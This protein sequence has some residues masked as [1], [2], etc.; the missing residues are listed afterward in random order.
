MVLT[1]FTIWEFASEMFERAVAA[2]LRSLRA[3]AAGGKEHPGSVERKT[4][5]KSNNILFH[6]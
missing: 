5:T 2:Y 3:S 4:E 1:N 6:F